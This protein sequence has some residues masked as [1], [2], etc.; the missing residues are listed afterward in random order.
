M[1]VALHKADCVQWRGTH[2]DLIP[3]HPVLN[4]LDRLVEAE[5]DHTNSMLVSIGFEVRIGMAIQAGGA[6]PFLLL[7]NRRRHKHTKQRATNGESQ[8]GTSNGVHW[9]GFEGGE[10]GPGRSST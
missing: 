7:E 3:R 10:R 4:L 9:H 1:R 6:L 5:A 8:S 2:R